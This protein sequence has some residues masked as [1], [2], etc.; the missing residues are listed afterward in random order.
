MMKQDK[1]P[2]QI[3]STLYSD[4]RSHCKNNGLVLKSLVE[5]LIKTELE[6]NGIHL[7]T[8]ETG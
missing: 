4:L 6:K 3:D 5:K 8:Q 1:K 7:S 2:I